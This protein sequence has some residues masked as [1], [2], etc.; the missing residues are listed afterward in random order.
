MIIIIGIITGSFFLKTNFEIAHFKKIMPERPELFMPFSKKKDKKIPDKP[1]P[2]HYDRISRKNPL[3][4]FPGKHFPI[5]NFLPLYSILLVYTASFSIRFI[6]KWR[7]DEKIRA[8]VEKER[9]SSE[10][11]FLKQ[12]V[13]PHFLFNSLNSIYSLSLSKSKNTTNA[14]LKLSS[15][16]RYML[17]ETDNKQVP[18]TEELEIIKSY[19]DIQKLRITKKVKV[20]IDIT[21]DP[22]NYKIEPLLLIPFIENAFKYG[23]DNINDSFIDIIIVILKNKLEFTVKN[24]IVQ[25]PDDKKQNSGIGIKNIKRRLD[26]LYANNYKL[27]IKKFD[28][29]YFVNL[30]LN[31]KK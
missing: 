12:Q 3:Q 6:Q 20:N 1:M 26:L 30:C 5:R 17:Y 29:I 11:S 22:D 8:E 21:G 7:E 25:K 9:V 31:L 14:I 27:D 19:I 2:K 15:I 28:D 10:L 4:P 16:L 24:K 18:L 13:N 23:V